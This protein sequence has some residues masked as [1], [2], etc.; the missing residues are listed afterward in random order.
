MSAGRNRLRLLLSFVAM[1]TRRVFSGCRIRPRAESIASL[2][3]R[4]APGPTRRYWYGVVRPKYTATASHQQTH[5]KH[6]KSHRKMRLIDDLRISSWP[7]HLWRCCIKVVWYECLY[8]P[9]WL[10]FIDAFNCYKQ[11]R[12]L[13]PFNLAHPVRGATCDKHI[14][15]FHSVCYRFRI[16]VYI[17]GELQLL[18]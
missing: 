10:N 6:S 8:V 12:K 9:K 5:Y 18:N 2:A 17:C 14:Y 16:S 11:K 7:H 1:A 13:A 3:P 4:H 15:W